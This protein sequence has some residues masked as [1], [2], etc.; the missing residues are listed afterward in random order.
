MVVL[1]TLP[2][3]ALK[4][5]FCIFYSK[6]DDENDYVDGGTDDEVFLGHSSK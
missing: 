3:F 6:G 1:S 4:D 2:Y 5:I